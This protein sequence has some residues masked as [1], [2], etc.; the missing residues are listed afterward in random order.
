M[1][2]AWICTSPMA[3][4]ELPSLGENAAF[5]IEQETRIG[6]SVYDRLLVF[7]LI[8]SEPVLDS[9]INDLGFRLLAGLDERFR[10]YKFFIVRDDSVNAFAVPGGYIGINRGLIRH[11]Q[12]QHQLA[13]V[14]AHEIAHVRLMHGM[15]ML[16]KSSEVNTA[17]LLTV[18]AGLLLGSADSH[19]GSAVLFGGVA[20]GQQ[21]MVNFTRENE[22]EADRVGIE[23]LYQAG[24]DTNGTVENVYHHGSAFWKR[25]AWDRIPSHPPAGYESC[26]RGDRPRAAART[27]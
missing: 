24:F 9:Y 25:R 5:N 12:T 20:G 19:V 6:R 18:L 16:N 3:I 4:S 21:A 17:T 13:S 8:E 7:G 22:Y 1:A 26:R 11:A 27:R 2:L 15:D 14:I 10:D 23:L